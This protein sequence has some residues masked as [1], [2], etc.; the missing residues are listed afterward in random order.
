MPGGQKDPPGLTAI[1][2]RAI[3][4]KEVD[5]SNKQNTYL[6]STEERAALKADLTDYYETNGIAQ[7]KKQIGQKVA[8]KLIN[9][10]G[11][12]QISAEQKELFNKRRRKE[13]MT[14]E[15]WDRKLKRE[16][17]ENLTQEQL[18]RQRQRMRKENKTKEQNDRRNTREGERREEIRNHRAAAAAAA[19][20]TTSSHG[21]LMKLPDKETEDRLNSATKVIEEFGPK[22]YVH[23]TVVEKENL[24]K[25][26]GRK[27]ANDPEVTLYSQLALMEGVPHKDLPPRLRKWK[28]T[29]K[30]QEPHNCV[31]S[32]PLVSVAMHHLR[33]EIA[34]GKTIDLHVM[35]SRVGPRRRYNPRPVPW[36]WC[37]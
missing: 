2:L 22:C 20:P 30:Q 12:G 18:D 8:Q 23:G 13:N 33:E 28:P 15:Q 36:R 27:Y 37:R 1:F 10:A 21:I 34:A 7:T 19:R 14:D 9:L 5:T 32:T 26:A 17:K 11:G 3:E 29:T 4:G 16:R 25:P 6:L 31:Y 24:L 35:M